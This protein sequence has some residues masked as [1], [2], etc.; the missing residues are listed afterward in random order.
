[1]TFCE[2]RE[3]LFDLDDLLRGAAKKPEQRFAEG[4]AQN[5]QPAERNDALREV[6]IAPP[7][8]GVGER[9]EIAVDREVASERGRS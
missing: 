7:G 2:K 9:G 1:V 3:H 6:W 5:A 8:Q 4:L